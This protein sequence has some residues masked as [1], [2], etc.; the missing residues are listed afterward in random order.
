MS[1]LDRRRFLR[2]TAGL[3]GATALSTAFGTRA[4]AQDVSRI[5]HAWWG[6]PERDKR[7]FAVI[8]IFNEKHPNIEVVG[9][10]LGFND[11]FTRLATQIAG[12][13]MPDVIQ[14]GYGVM[15]E[16]VDRGTM[17]P[18]TEYIGKTITIDDVDESAIAAGTFNGE[19][20]GLTIG[21]NTMATVY[22]TT[23]VEQGGEEFDPITW[24]YD[25]LKRV[26][27][28]ISEATPEGVYGTDDSTADWGAFGVF[29][30]QNGFAEQYTDDGK[31]FTFDAQLVIDFWNMWKDIRDAGGTPPGAESAGLAGQADL[32]VQGVVTGMTA[33]T[34]AWSNQIVGIQDLMQD[35]VGAAMRPHLAGG[36]PGQSVQPSQFVCLSRDTVDPEAA[37]TYMNAFVHDPD[38][39]KVLGLE[40][41][42]PEVASVR[43]MLAP[44]LSEAEAITVAY[45]DAI[46]GHIGPLPPAPPAGNREV[47]ELF[48]RIAVN[49]LL[50]RQS[51]EDTAN[52]FMQEAR[53][54]LRR[55]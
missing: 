33:I 32:T 18:L 54:I 55:A 46:Q 11:Y 37:T 50:D 1:R 21:A 22:N 20:Y 28:A 35:K 3:A 6:N 49:I 17:I 43:E 30:S 4:F 40:R 41:G 5:R 16:Y 2:T 34:Y 12:G 39:T 8:E 45:F 24:T 14:Q 13:N 10:T 31:D 47:E 53:G 51:I 42:I 7:T 48:E 26:A 15:Q 36:E 9:E 44:T 52:Q 29:S 38:M 19:L 27:V 23:L 25:D